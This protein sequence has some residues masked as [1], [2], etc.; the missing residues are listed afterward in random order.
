MRDGRL[1]P[2]VC[3]DGVYVYST[4]PGN[5]YTYLN[6]TSMSCPGVSGTV[7]QLV[8][9]YKQ[10]FSV[11][12]PA[13]LVRA[14]VCNTADDLGNT[15]P[16]FKFGYGRINGLRAVQ[17]FENSHFKM[18]SVA[19]S[20]IIDDT[21]T[22]PANTKQL[23]VMVCW[24][25]PAAPSTL[26]YTA[27]TLI[28]NLDMRV[29][30][31]N[32]A[33]YYPFVLNPANPSATATNGI[34][35]LNNIE[36][37]VID[38]PGAGR[39]FV[40]VSGT[41]VPSGPQV[42]A[43]TYDMI[44]NG[45]TVTYPCGA[46]KLTPGSTETIRWDAYGNSGKFVVEYS[47]NNGLNWKAVDTNISSGKRYCQWTV[48]DTSSPACL[49]RVSS[50][51]GLTDICDTDFSIM[52]LPGTLTSS[53]C[54][55]QLT[56][57]WNPVRSA[58][59]YSLYQLNTGQWSLAANTSDTFFTV[60]GLDNKTTYWYS[61]TAKN[62]F[63]AISEHS[64]GV[65]FSP[66]STK[67]HP[68][69]TTH[70]FINDTVCVGSSKTLIAGISGTPS[71]IKQWQVSTNNGLSWNSVPG[72]TDTFLTLTNIQ[73]SQDKFRYRLSV[74]NLCNETV[75]S[76]A[77]VLQVDTGLVFTVS[78]QN[79]TVCT[80]KQIRLSYHSLSKATFSFQWQKSTD[81]G[82]NWIDI[83]GSHD[84]IL[85]FTSLYS[86]NTN[87]FRVKA[88]DIC[89]SAI[90]SGA[91]TLTVKPQLTVVISSNVDS[92]YA[93]D[94]LLLVANQHGGDSL[95]YHLRWSGG[96]GVNDSIFVHPVVSTT[97]IAR[98]FDDCSVDSVYDTILIKVQKHP[99]FRSHSSGSWE[100]A[101][102]WE[103]WN[104]SA[105]VWPAPS[106]PTISDSL[107]SIK[108]ADSVHIS[109]DHSIRNLENLRKVGNC[110]GSHGGCKW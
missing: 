31:S 70:P 67:Y 81:H 98:L 109:A 100:S 110:P 90:Y 9:R 55:N 19:A 101:A 89:Y 28:N 27:K 3:A 66:D 69:F 15:G 83:S 41:S 99:E 104:G 82:S 103:K 52:Y 16:D 29:I 94:S 33:A 75:Y 61:I 38:N 26:P 21:I 4:S 92:I 62:A 50:T 72:A 57:K 42:Y 30:D 74:S 43:L 20:G 107:I 63:N 97:Y 45:I 23:K 95:N 18:K 53:A 64:A 2:E 32:S 71:L 8:Q 85:A 59:A 96:L 37:V 58:T 49:V 60:S 12:P 6:G 36:Q 79:T 11:N 88:S 35:T 102:S 86:Q 13:S 87:K 47:L 25:D 76:N 84:T 105:W 48:P 93:G 10:L 56:L 39:Y 17:A 91:A 5:N 51:N 65:S 46:E 40:R 14:V 78:P 24:S 7:A 22:V 54:N 80:G 106:I 44:P 77:V 73:K 34:D 1:K 108:S 68:V